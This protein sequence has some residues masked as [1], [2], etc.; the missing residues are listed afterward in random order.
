MGEAECPA[1]CANRT[2]KPYFRASF[3]FHFPGGL[4]A[5]GKGTVMGISANL[6]LLEVWLHGISVPEAELRRLVEGS[7]GPS[8][9]E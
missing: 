2:T 4:K 3:A 5:L 1:N 7:A 6:G 9:K 8:G